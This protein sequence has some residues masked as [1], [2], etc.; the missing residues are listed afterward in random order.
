MLTAYNAVLSK[1]F[2]AVA[3]FSIVP[4]LGVE[5][6]NVKGLQ[7]GGTRSGAAVEEKSDKATV[8]APKSG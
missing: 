2:T 3:C 6:R 7:H 8:E 1:A 4:A 5:W